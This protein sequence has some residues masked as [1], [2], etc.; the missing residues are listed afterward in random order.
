MPC[1]NIDYTANIQRIILINQI[2]TEL[3]S[4]KFARKL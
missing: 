3:F 1:N 4:K 2:I